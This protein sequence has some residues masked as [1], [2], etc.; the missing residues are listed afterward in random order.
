[1]SPPITDWLEIKDALSRNYLPPTYRSSLLK[2]WDRLKQGTALMAKYIEKF[3]EFKRGIRIVEEEVVT[4]NRLKKGLNANLLDEI[5]T[6]GVTTLG[7]AYDLVRKCELVSKPIFWRFFELWSVPTNSQPFGSKSRLVLPPKVNPNSTSIEKKD[8]GK[9]VVNEPSR[10]GSRLQC[11]KCNGVGH[12][13]ARCPFKTLVMQEDDEKVEDVEELVYDPNVEEIQDVEAEWEDDRSYLACIRAISPQVDDFNDI[14]GVLRVNVVRCA[15][16]E[17]RN[18]NDWRMSA[19][20]QTYTKCG[21]KTCKVIINSGSCINAVSSNVGSHLGLKLNPH[22]NPYKVSWVDTSS[23]AMKERCVV[24][25]QFLTYKAKIWC[26]VIP[27]DVGHI[28]LTRPW[29]YDLDVTHHGRSNSC[30]FVFEGKKIVLNPLKPKPI[31]MSKK[32]EALKAKGLNIISPKAFEQ[33]AVQEFIVFVLVARELYG[34]THEEQL[35]EVQSVLQEFKDVFL[36]D[37]PDHLSPMRDIN[38]P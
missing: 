4:L 5:I 17:Q 37:L 26:D 21:D 1:M 8:K 14:F 6:R 27:M 28:I 25:F 13:V 34:E 23:I 29:L 31:D 15:L 35:E 16:A 19:I 30:S 36:E 3:K 7:E 10:L 32:I 24:P 18:T 11:F 33:V 12:I 38:T 9:S 22:T 2:E 20:F